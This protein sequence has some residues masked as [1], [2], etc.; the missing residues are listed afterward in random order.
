M[1]RACAGRQRKPAFLRPCAFHVP[2]RL[3][4]CRNSCL[5]PLCSRLLP[6]LPAQT[7]AAIP[8]RRRNACGSCPLFFGAPHFQTPC[9][10]SGANLRFSQKRKHF[11]D[12]PLG[13][14][15]QGTCS[16]FGQGTDVFSRFC[17]K[18]FPVQPS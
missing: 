11:P 8:G 17:Q 9:F 15:H 10:S 13:T 5:S 4:I 2:M 16:V 3:W 7:E 12:L 14:K 6:F 1:T 18:F